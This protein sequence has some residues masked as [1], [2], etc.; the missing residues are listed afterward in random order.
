MVPD[1]LSK[2]IID[3]L[4]MITNITYHPNLKSNPDLSNINP[5]IINAAWSAEDLREHSR[6]EAERVL[7]WSSRASGV[8]DGW[9]DI[10]EIWIG[11]V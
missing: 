11:L 6:S 3:H 4:I 2:V 9:I 1:K 10:G 8:Y 5:S 7:E